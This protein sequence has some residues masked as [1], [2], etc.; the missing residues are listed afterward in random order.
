M[1]NPHLVPISKDN[2][3]LDGLGNPIAQFTCKSCDR[4]F[5]RKEVYPKDSEHLVWDYGRVQ[6]KVMG[7]HCEDTDE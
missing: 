2:Q 5:T 1:A 4:V 3:P 7:G 6:V